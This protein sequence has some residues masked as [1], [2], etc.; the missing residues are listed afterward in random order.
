M[1][2]TKAPQHYHYTSWTW[3]QY[4]SDISYHKEHH[5]RILG[6]KDKRWIK[7]SEFAFTIGNIL[8]KTPLCGYASYWRRTDTNWRLTWGFPQS[9][10][11]W[12]SAHHCPNI[13]WSS[14]PYHES[15]WLYEFSKGTLLTIPKTWHGI[16]NSTPSW[17]YHVFKKEKIQSKWCPT[18]MFLQIRHW[19]E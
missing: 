6:N 1:T 12:P 16:S 7:V 4:L 15:N 10:G 18:S 11:W 17:T 19:R 3:N 8:W 13:L 5:P 14:I 2:Q 9:L